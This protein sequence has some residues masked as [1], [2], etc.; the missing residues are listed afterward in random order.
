MKK[1][2]LPRD[3]DRVMP[4]KRMRRVSGPPKWRMLKAAVAWRVM[5]RFF[6]N[7]SHRH[8][9]MWREDLKRLGH[10]SEFGKSSIVNEVMADNMADQ[11]LMLGE[12]EDDRIRRKLGKDKTDE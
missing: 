11:I 4:L 8:K 7:K 1:A 9:V 2:G 12:F 6:K 10:S 3:Y 5:R